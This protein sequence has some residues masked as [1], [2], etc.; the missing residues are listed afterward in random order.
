MVA[1]TETGHT[2]EALTL[3]LK[4]CYYDHFW[5]H[6]QRDRTARRIAYFMVWRNVS[7]RVHW[8]PRPHS[9]QAGGF[10]RIFRDPHCI[11]ADAIPDMYHD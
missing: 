6:L 5:V 10:L 1:F 9:H 4:D 2:R 11:F 8:V 3:N 7:D